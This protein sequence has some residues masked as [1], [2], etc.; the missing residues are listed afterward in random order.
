M[1]RRR[2]AAGKREGQRRREGEIYF[3]PKIKV[4]PFLP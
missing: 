4:S 1:W 2:E 3:W